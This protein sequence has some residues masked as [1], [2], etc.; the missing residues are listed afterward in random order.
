MIQLFLMRFMLVIFFTSIFF[1]SLPYRFNDYY[2][3]I[4][5]NPII[6]SLIIKNEARLY[7]DSILATLTL[8]EKI[9]QCI[10]VPVYPKK[11]EQH[12]RNVESLIRNKKI[13]GIIFFR[14]DSKTIKNLSHRFSS[15]A[16]IPLWIAMDAEWG[17]SM[18]V[19]NIPKLP[20]ALTLGAIRDNAIVR[21]YGQ[22]VGQQCVELGIN[23]N[24]SPI[25]DVNINPDNP[26][27]N[28]RSFGEIPENVFIKAYSYFLG[29]NDLNVIAVAKHFPGHGNTN[30][31]SHYEL[32]IIQDDVETIKSVHLYPFSQLIKRGIQ[33]IM[34]AHVHVPALEKN[35][36][37]STL[38]KRIISEILID[39]LNFQGLVITD[40][41]GMQGVIKDRNPG[42]VELLALES[43]C[44]ILLMPENIQQA[45]DTIRNAVLKN[46]LSEEI[47]DSRCK[48]VLEYKYIYL[49][50]HKIMDNKNLSEKNITQNQTEQFLQEIFDKSV[51]LVYQKKDLLPINEQRYKNILV[52]STCNHQNTHLTEVLSK[53]LNVKIITISKNIGLGEIDKI[54]NNIK[55]HNYDLVIIAIYGLNNKPSDNYGITSQIKTFCQ[56]VSENASTILTLF[57]NPYALNYLGNLR[58]HCGIVVAYE[59]NKYAEYAVGRAILGEINFCGMLPV[60]AGS[61]RAGTGI[62]QNNKPNLLEEINQDFLANNFE[63]KKY[64]DS[65]D[66][67][68]EK[69]ISENTFPGCQVLIAQNGKVFYHKS[70]GYHTY[71]KNKKVELNHLYDLASLTKILAT[72]LTIMKLYDEGSIQLN[73]SIASF[74]KWTKGTAIGSLTIKEILAHQS[75]L[76]SW[77]PFYKQTIASDSLRN[78]YYSNTRTDKFVIQV[79]K[80]IWLRADYKDT[81]YNI[82]LNTPLKRK[83]YR[84]SDLGFIL[85]KEIIENIT[86]RN[87]AEYLD[88]EFYQLL[89]LYRLTF[90]PL[91][92]YHLDEIVPTEND[93]IYRKQLIHGFVHDPAAAM[94]GGYSGN[95]GL[96]GNAWSVASILQLF[97]NYGKVYDMRLLDSLTIVQFT[98]RQFPANRRGLGFDKPSFKNEKSNT[99]I[100][101]SP[102]SYGHSGFTGTFAWADPMYNLIVVFLSNRI[103]PD[104]NNK[105]IQETKI[106]ENIQ[107]FAYRFIGVN[108]KNKP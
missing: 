74:L 1:L 30:Q 22:F 56:Y 16:E 14:G 54:L 8:E 77:I 108:G 18:R 104:A 97:L 24:M 47:I 26:V 29:L 46:K 2:D 48:K 57:G 35:N 93:T 68:I 102:F 33:A 100:L 58:Q 42:Q 15:I 92:W 75:G 6:K 107:Y 21:K 50:A 4:N 25:A 84:Y 60:S 94:L 83:Q 80:D 27:I 106:R 67:L 39:S 28:Y 61:F 51:T 53:K 105:R 44:H 37:P 10:I 11:D 65:I 5:D 13:G 32:P 41:L 40:A 99:S 3:N 9:S 66:M 38:S 17:V 63:N 7:A 34:T 95:A 19:E 76:E 45:V 73:D 101:A 87:F 59:E 36:I 96:F 103:H 52:L 62:N 98:S 70:F 55:N 85:L 71:D 88:D 81:I 23:M 20:F 91:Q 43:G 64:L 90:Q 82:I 79:A 78:V 31:D 12:F 69:A 89:Q 49:I 86:N 72:T